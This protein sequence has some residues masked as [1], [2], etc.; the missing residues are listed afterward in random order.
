ME[1]WWL[2]WGGWEEAG[3]GVPPHQPPPPIVPRRY[4]LSSDFDL[5]LSTPSTTPS[6]FHNPYHTSPQHGTALS[7][8]L[9]PLEALFSPPP[10]SPPPP[11]PPQSSEW[12]PPPS[13][14]AGHS[15]R[16]HVQPTAPPHPQSP[17]YAT[18]SITMAT[19]QP[20]LQNLD[21]LLAKFPDLLKPNERNLPQEQRNLILRKR[22]QTFVAQQAAQRKG[23]V[24]AALLQQKAQQAQA[25]AAAAAAGGVRP[26]VQAGPSQSP[27]VMQT[28]INGQQMQM[29]PQVSSPTTSC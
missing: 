8:A 20:Q 18:G 14:A 13:D 21:A 6:S 22:V 16:K 10:S 2:R 9:L 26:N 17:P 4:S 19:P 23:Q 12:L 3:G 25:Q 15:A 27:R 24:D 5:I 28:Q 11:P 7:A 29:S 1:R